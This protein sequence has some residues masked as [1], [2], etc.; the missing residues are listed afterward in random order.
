MARGEKML[1][2]FKPYLWVLT[3][4]VVS[5]FWFKHIWDGSLSYENE[6]SYTVIIIIFDFLVVLKKTVFQKKSQK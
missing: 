3:L 5:L 4:V 1:N 2:H 6:I